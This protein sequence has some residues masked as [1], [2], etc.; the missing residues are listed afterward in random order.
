MAIGNARLYGLEEDLGLVG[1]Q[2]QIAVS[3][4]F[5]TYCVSYLRAQSWSL[6]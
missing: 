6:H 5:I 4:L 2:F 3:V 1:E